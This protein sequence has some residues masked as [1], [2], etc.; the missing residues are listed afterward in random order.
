M[1]TIWYT[2]EEEGDQGDNEVLVESSMGPFATLE[3]AE[4]RVGLMESEELSVARLRPSPI[5][6]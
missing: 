2:I 5:K 1:Y 4:E 6:E 3:E